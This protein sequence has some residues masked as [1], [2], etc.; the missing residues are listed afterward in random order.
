MPFCPTCRSEY[1]AG[2]ERCPDCKVELVEKLPPED[3]GAEPTAK[4]VE[5]YVAAGDEEAV[6]IRGLLESEGIMSSLSSDIPHTV[7]PLNV[8]GLGAVRIAVAEEDAGRAR[9]IIAAHQEE[10][11][12]E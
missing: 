10:Q 12:A 3:A 6:I 11:G 1:E 8:D 2:I 7:V 4:I 5:V 9:E